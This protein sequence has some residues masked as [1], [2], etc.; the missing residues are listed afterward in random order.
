MNPILLAVLKLLMP[1]TTWFL[2][3]LIPGRNQRL[4]HLESLNKLAIMELVTSVSSV[5]PKHPPFPSLKI[6]VRNCYTLGE[7]ESLWTIEGLGQRKIE[8][9]LKS[10]AE[11]QDFLTG[12][13]NN[14]LPSESLAMLHAGIGLGFAKHGLDRLKKSINRNL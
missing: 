12:E 2:A 6:L 11:P 3:L 13:E 8:H 5:L 1:V 10:S 7:Y 14:D 4:A 9:E